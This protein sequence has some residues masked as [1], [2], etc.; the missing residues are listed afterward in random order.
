[1][2]CSWLAKQKVV[3]KKELPIIDHAKMEYPTF[4]KNFYVESPEISSMTAEEVRVSC[5]SGCA[6][7]CCRVYF[8]LPAPAYPVDLLL[9]PLG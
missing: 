2:L 3:K 7:R 5:R 8:C 1:M 9:S 4:R 6:C